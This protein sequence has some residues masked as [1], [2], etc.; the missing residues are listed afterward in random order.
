MKRSLIRLVATLLLIC[1]TWLSGSTN[2]LA[3]NPPTEV[4]PSA[5]NLLNFV[6]EMGTIADQAF[7]ATNK[8]DF[9]QAETLW[10]DLIEKFPQNPAIWSNRGNSRVS[11]NKL[12]D[13]IADYDQAIKLAPDAPDPYLNRGAA[14]EGLGKYEEAIANYNHVLELDPK[15]PVAYGNRGNAESKLG[16]WE[17][18]IEDFKTAADLAPQYVFARANYALALYQVGKTDDAIRNMRHL[19][20][21]YPTFADMR[22]ALTAALWVE[23]NQGEAESQWVSTVGLDTR[24]KNIDWVENVRHWPPKMVAALRKF[25]ELK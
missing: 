2:S 23:G 3:D 18:A 24:Y 8:G 13:A 14:L 1:S 12:T 5:A 17:Q 21:K 10:T 22:A 25:L 11:Q 7:E 20:R 6:Q 15:D 9:A 16:Q 19:V 4:V